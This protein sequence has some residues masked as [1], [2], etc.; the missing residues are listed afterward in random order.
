MPGSGTGPRSSGWETLVYVILERTLPSGT[1]PNHSMCYQRKHREE[2]HL[3]AISP[4]YCQPEK[5]APWRTGNLSGITVIWVRLNTE[6][7]APHC[8]STPNYRE[9]GGR[10]GVPTQ[11]RQYFFG[12]QVCQHHIH[13]AVSRFCGT[14]FML[15]NLIQLHV[16]L[17]S[18]DIKSRWPAL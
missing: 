15:P 2:M 16:H 11:C 18:V 1:E 5:S 3:P 17:K 4:L 14:D 10:V 12:F 9:R 6:L 7:Q 8:R 13:T